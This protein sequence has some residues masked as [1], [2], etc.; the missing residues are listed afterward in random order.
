MN[1]ELPYKNIFLTNIRG[2]RWKDVPGLEH[3]CMI[4][5]LGRIKRLAYELEYSDGRIYYKPD[6]IIRPAV[7]KLPNSFV[8]EPILFLRNSVTFFGK[9]YNFSIARLVYYCFVET[10]DMKDNYIVV[11]PKDGNGLNIKPSNLIKVSHGDK[12]KRMYKLKRNQSAFLNEENRKKGYLPSV[13]K[14]SKIISQYNLEGRK[15]KTYPGATVAARHAGV[16]RS[17]ISNAARGV[18]KSAGG[19]LWRY[20]KDSN[21]PPFTDLRKHR[22]K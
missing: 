2:E 10:F 1:R 17:L 14:N 15:I 11:L 3:Y 4:S 6:Q 13:L 22:Y 8:N 19:Y 5:S 16:S 20:G 12:Q 7:M 21:V 18:E 9:K